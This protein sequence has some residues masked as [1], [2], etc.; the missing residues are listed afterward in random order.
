MGV[1]CIFF[2]QK[3]VFVKHPMYGALNTEVVQHIKVCYIQAER[4]YIYVSYGRYLWGR[5]N[6]ETCVRL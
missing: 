3:H 6:C 1:Q 5:H 4:K 2:V